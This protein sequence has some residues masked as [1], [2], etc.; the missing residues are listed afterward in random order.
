MT[1]GHSL[2][3]DVHLSWE[4]SHQSAQHSQEFAHLLMIF[5]RTRHPIPTPVLPGPA[6]RQ[7]K[8]SPP[9]WLHPHL[10]WPSLPVISVFGEHALFPS[11][12]PSATHIADWLVSHHLISLSFSGIFKMKTNCA[13]V[14]Q[15]DS[16]TWIV[17][18]PFC[19]I[20]GQ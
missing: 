18:C 9:T 11:D 19:I 8:H 16:F 20:K 1:N 6:T 12:R 4:D 17:H 15:R 7:D 10:V 5:A 2:S 3:L 13:L 14:M